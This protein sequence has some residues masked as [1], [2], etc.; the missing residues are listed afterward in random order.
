MLECS[1][2]AL[3]SKVD[4]DMELEPSKF[5]QADKNLPKFMN[6]SEQGKH[7]QVAGKQKS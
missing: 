6:G 1:V 2:V 4:K 7:K 5:R 3:N